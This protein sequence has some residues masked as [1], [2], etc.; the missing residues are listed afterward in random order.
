MRN[1]S[2]FRDRFFSFWFVLFNS[3]VDN[4]NA[5]NAAASDFPAE[6]ATRRT[7]GGSCRRTAA[8]LGA[9]C[10]VGTRT[11]V[12]IVEIRDDASIGVK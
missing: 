6:A 10:A 7:K 2:N 8:T 11:F 12:S 1:R 3:V 5:E 9:K 4:L